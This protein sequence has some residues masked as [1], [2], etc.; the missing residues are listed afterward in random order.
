[1]QNLIIT[2]AESLVIELGYLTKELFNQRT[3][4]NFLDQ[5]PNG[6][7][8]PVYLI[9]GLANDDRAFR[10]LKKILFL[11]GFNAQTWQLG[12]NLGPTHGLERRVYRSFKKFYD[13]Y[14]PTNIVGHSLGGTFAVAIAHHYPDMIDRVVTVGGAHNISGIHPLLERVYKIATGHTIEKSWKD[15]SSRGH[16]IACETPVFHIYGTKD[17]LLRSHNTCMQGNNPELSIDIETSHIGLLESWLCA[18]TIILL[19]QISIPKNP[20]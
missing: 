14:G 18:Y 12:M 17:T 11:K 3:I 16:H 7:G 8:K 9:P 19:L 1:M 4:Y 2:S 20:T 5:L 6:N 10:F 13:Q 15:L